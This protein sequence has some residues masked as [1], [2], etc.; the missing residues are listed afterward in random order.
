[1]T[2]QV[3]SLRTEFLED[4][5]IAALLTADAQ[6][7]LWAWVLVGLAGLLIGGA[8]VADQEPLLPISFLSKP[9]LLPAALSGLLLLVKTLF[10]WQACEFFATCRRNG[11]LEALLTTPLTDAEIYRGQWASLRRNFGP[12]L[13]VLCVLLAVGPLLQAVMSSKGTG[14]TFP[15]DQVRTFGIWLYVVINLP[16]ELMAIAWF[17]MWLALTETRPGWA[18]AKTVAFVVVLPQILFCVPSLLVAGAVFSYARGKLMRPI[19]QVLNGT[20]DPHR[21]WTKVGRQSREG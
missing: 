4:Q 8:I 3:V 12:P 17:G 13:I 10:A 6:I 19:R 15:A 14:G 9:A 7:R 21:Y 16:L 1:V 2:R 20:R 5:P 11:A 18:F